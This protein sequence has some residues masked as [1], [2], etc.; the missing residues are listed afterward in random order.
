MAAFG[1]ASADEIHAKATGAD[2]VAGVPEGGMGLLGRGEFERHAIEG[3]EVPAMR[4]DIAFERGE[5]DFE[6]FFEASLGAA[7]AVA[8]EVVFDGGDAA[9]DTDLEPPVGEL[10]EHADLFDEPERVIE[11]EEVHKRAEFE[12]LRMAGSGGEEDRL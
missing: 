2:D 10:V 7:G 4:E 8:P 6:G 1:P 3:E 9:A 11:G 12:G 5:E